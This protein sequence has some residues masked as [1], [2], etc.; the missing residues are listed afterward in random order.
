[1]RTHPRSSPLRAT[2]ARWWTLLA[3]LAAIALP[4]AA[5]VQ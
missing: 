1:M 5:Q 4:A 2:L 3:L